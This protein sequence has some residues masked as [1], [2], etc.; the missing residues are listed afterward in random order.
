MSTRSIVTFVS[1]GAYGGVN[2]H[3]VY[4][5]HDG[6]PEV[7]GQEVLDFLRVLRDETK[8]PRFGDSHKLSAKFVVYMFEQYRKMNVVGVSKGSLDSDP[9][10]LGTRSVALVEADTLVD[11]EYTYVVFCGNLDE[12]SIPVVRMFKGD[13]RES[14]FK[15][16]KDDEKPY[17]HYDLELLA[18]GQEVKTLL[19][20]LE[21]S[22]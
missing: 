2:Q 15:S 6:Y 13:I 3:T 16:M 22:K 17:Q 19:K 7:R 14:L 18:E 8:D 21:R 4:V 10:Y 20:K 9:H 1:P 12:E 11:A 5:H